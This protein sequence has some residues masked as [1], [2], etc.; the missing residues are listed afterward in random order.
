MDQVITQIEK[1]NLDNI[2]ESFWR[3]DN[4]SLD[5]QLN[6]IIS[7][8]DVIEV[9]VRNGEKE[10]EHRRLKDGLSPIWLKKHIF[11][12]HESENN[13]L[14]GY[15]DVWLTLDHMYKRLGNKVVYFFV[16]QF[17]KTLLASFI[18]LLIFH[19]FIFRHVVAIDRY[20]EKFSVKNIRYLDKYIKLPFK[21]RENNELTRLRNTINDILKNVK[22]HEETLI[23]QIDI[24]KNSNFNLLE[25]Q[26]K[27]NL[28][29]KLGDDTDASVNSIEKILEKMSEKFAADT[30]ESQD[31]KRIRTSFAFIS[32]SLERI[33]LILS[34][35]KKDANQESTFEVVFSLFKKK[36]SLANTKNI[37]LEL[38]YESFKNM[39]CPYSWI[40]S[41]IDNI[42]EVRLPEIPERGKINLELLDDDGDFYLKIWD[43]GARPDYELRKIFE[44]EKN[45]EG[46]NHSLGVIQRMAMQ[47]KGRFRIDSNY[48]GGAMF[49]LILPR[50]NKEA[51]GDVSA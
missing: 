51:Q 37:V 48:I 49:E 11:E 22:D 3:I 6:G 26:S 10:I 1:A 24:L 42:I 7:I 21:E 40:N 12:M 35:E 16:T 14:I 5:T 9:T 41:A 34:G 20:F 29:S 43:T 4:E 13:K 27:V 23:T 33:N 28:I 17:I 15:L 25:S 36:F 30:E 38:K 2:A 19:H 39:V 8:N 32:A 45:L 46:L 18:M 47:A 44:E 31:V 50:I